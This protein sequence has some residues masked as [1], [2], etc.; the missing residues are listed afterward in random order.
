MLAASDVGR[1]AD[2]S[3][4]GGWGTLGQGGGG[5]GRG[6]GDGGPGRAGAT[7]SVTYRRRS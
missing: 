7:I 1:E 2:R 4:D 5:D 3:G 6:G